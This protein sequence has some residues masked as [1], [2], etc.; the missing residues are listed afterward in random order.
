MKFGWEDYEDGEEWSLE[1]AIMMKVREVEESGHSSTLVIH[2]EGCTVNGAE[3][4]ECF[5]SPMKVTI[6][7]PMRITH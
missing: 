6:T 1:E 5:C 4:L 7:K 2:S 3:Q